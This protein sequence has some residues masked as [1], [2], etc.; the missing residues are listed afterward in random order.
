[1]VNLP[2]AVGISGR[3]YQILKSDAGA[4]TVTV[5]PNGAEKI[6]GAATFVLAAQYKTVRVISNGANWMIL[7]SN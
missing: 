4:N 1:M 5:T 6:N 3:E 7:T 2:T